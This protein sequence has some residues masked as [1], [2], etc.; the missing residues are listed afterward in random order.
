[1][2]ASFL[3]QSYEA[4]CLRKSNVT[5]ATAHLRALFEAELAEL[6]H[7]ARA[8]GHLDTQHTRVI[9]R[10]VDVFMVADGG[11]TDKSC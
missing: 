6:W 1:M 10:A 11:G 2:V 8:C 5:V 9:N 4:G 7:F 3:Q